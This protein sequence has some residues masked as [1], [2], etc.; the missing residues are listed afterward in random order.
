MAGDRAMRVA[1]IHHW[2]VNW[3]GGE[4]VLK[5][6]TEIFPQADIYTHVY[7]E[8][9]VAREFPHQRVT[10]TFI[11]RLPFAR[12]WSQRYLPLMPLALEQ[13]D[14]RNYDLVISNESGPA[15][16]VIVAPHAH[17]LC[18]CLSPMRYVW[19]MYHEYRAGAGAVTRLLMPPIL[20]YLRT[21]DQISAQRPDRYVAISRFV[22]ARVAKYYGRKAEVIFPPVAVQDFNVSPQSEDFYLSVGQLVPYKRADLMVEAFNQSGKRLIVIG[23]GELL[24]KLQRMA[25]P[26]VQLL[27]WQP[28]EVIRDHYSRC[29]A[30]V[31]PGVEDFGI[32]PVEA[33]ACGKP[34]IAIGAGG[35][36]DTVVD[37][38]T[39]V[40]FSDHSVAG[41]NAAIA[42]FEGRTFDPH[43]IREHSLQFSN[44]RFAERFKAC[45]DELIANGRQLV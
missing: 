28:F 29:R 16:G 3:R 25:R 32:V 7:D 34:V 37:G 43:A 30:L 2:L 12:R 31:F 6:M 21:W 20:H 41:L 11:S 4:K 17:Y 9:L 44:E 42:D 35:I 19:D 40:L 22:A 10:G 14:L 38:H 39:G 5:S 27:G 15:K 45:V 18:Y 23:E 1:L 26:N 24:P 33:M 8:Q 36:L 13:L